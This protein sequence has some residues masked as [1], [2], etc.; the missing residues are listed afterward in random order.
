MKKIYVIA[1]EVQH[2]FDEDSIRPNLVTEVCFNFGYW[3]NECDAHLKCVELNAKEI[4][5]DDSEYQDEKYW[6]LGIDKEKIGT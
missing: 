6:V 2:G 4:P 1:T 3:E 5:E